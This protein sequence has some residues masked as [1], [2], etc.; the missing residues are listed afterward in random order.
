MWKRSKLHNFIIPYWTVIELDGTNTSKKSASVKIW[1][2]LIIPHKY[3][4]A[5]AISMLTNTWPIIAD[6]IVVSNCYSISYIVSGAASYYGAE[7][8]GIADASASGSLIL[9]MSRGLFILFVN[10]L[11]Y[12]SSN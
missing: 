10:A 11:G 12:K 6:F 1:E 4:R 2:A 7:V 9:S 5:V 3:Y 8:A